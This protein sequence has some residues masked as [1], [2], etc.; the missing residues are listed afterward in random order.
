MPLGREA[1]RATLRSA[2][3]PEINL[4]CRSGFP[5]CFFP[6]F[7]PLN[8]ACL[9][10]D[11]TSLP[12]CCETPRTFRRRLGMRGE[13]GGERSF[14]GKVIRWKR[15]SARRRGSRVAAG[16]VELSRVRS[17]QSEQR[18]QQGGRKYWYLAKTILDPC[19]SFSF[20]A[21]PC[22]RTPSSTLHSL[23]WP[24]RH[25]LLLRFR[26]ETSPVRILIR[27]VALL[28]S[29]DPLCPSGHRFDPSS[30]S[31]DEGSKCFSSR[32]CFATSPLLRLRSNQLF[33][34]SGLFVASSEREQVALLERALWDRERARE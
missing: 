31:S 21:P 1:N 12:A 24:R 6:F 20:S 28:V 23:T 30:K 5:P 19:L 11:D 27:I 15:E 9:H 22:H 18:Y 26:I 8:V 3:T 14:S 7:P 4:A 32:R 25:P 2:Y 34:P 17:Q 33:L 29:M 10:H 13:G 16:S